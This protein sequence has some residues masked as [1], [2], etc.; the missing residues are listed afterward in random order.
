MAQP[1]SEGFLSSSVPCFPL[2]SSPAVFYLHKH[3]WPLSCPEHMLFPALACFSLCFSHAWPC[4]VTESLA[5]LSPRE[6][7]LDHPVQSLTPRPSPQHPTHLHQG[8]SLARAVFSHG[9]LTG[10]PPRPTVGSRE[11]GTLC[12]VPVA[13]PASG[14]VPPCRTN[15]SMNECV[16]SLWV[17]L[18]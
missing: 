15:D 4:S 17:S 1:P 6:A 11:A 9:C 5:S 3:P 2:S 12:F 13:S 14:P 18:T 16:F 7:F 10:F 8:A